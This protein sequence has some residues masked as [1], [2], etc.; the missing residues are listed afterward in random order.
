MGSTSVMVNGI[1]ILLALLIPIPAV[2]QDLYSE[3]IE[4]A[5]KDP[6]EQ[7]EENEEALVESLIEMFAGIEATNAWVNRLD[8]VMR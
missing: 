1:L 3:R 2:G 5:N 8:G 4:A 6:L 7:A